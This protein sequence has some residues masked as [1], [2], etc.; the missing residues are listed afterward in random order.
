M[1]TLLILLFSLEAFSY[2]KEELAVVRDGKKAKE[3]VVLLK[4]LV[5]KKCFEGQ[6]FHILFKSSE[7][8]VCF[9]DDS[10][11]R[12]K[13]STVYHHLTIAREYFVQ[14][15]NL[16]YPDRD[17]KIKIRI[18]MDLPFDPIAYVRTNGDSQEFNNARTIPQGEG[19]PSRGIEPWGTEIWFMPKKKIH[20]REFNLNNGGNGITAFLQVYRRQTHVQNL[21]QALAL[22]IREGAMQSPDYLTT[23]IRLAGTS[24]FLE[25]I[26][27]NDKAF[28][29][30]FTRRYFWLETALVPEIIYHEYAHVA[31]SG[32][33][34]LVDRDAIV[35]GLADYFASSI[36]KSPELA[37]HI[38]K[39]NV[40]NGKD[41]ENNKPY[42]SDLELDDFANADFVLSLLWNLR[43]IIPTEKLDDFILL[44]SN[45]LT[46]S[47][48]VRRDLVNAILTSCREESW[49]HSGHLNKVKLMLYLRS[50]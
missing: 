35:E 21:T 34:N 13:A 18:D 43:E 19:F 42:S 37:K 22:N 31:L 39:Y 45:K 33:V 9:N 26:Y 40:I 41:A 27:Q 16:N 44:I 6:Y 7:K 11:I 48:V 50:F 14:K 36:A 15:L 32:I 46:Q 5:S 25:F 4:D 12:L 47:R 24:L 3:R 1:K 30:L 17:K 23:M 38:K 28:M 8:T 10:K 20:R 49:C 29:N 2:A